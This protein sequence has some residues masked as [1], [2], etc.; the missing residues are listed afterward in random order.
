MDRILRE[1]LA[2][3]VRTLRAN[4]AMASRPHF[5]PVLPLILGGDDLFA[6]VPAP[7]AL[8]IAGQLCANFER[9]MTK[10]AGGLGN[11]ARWLK[12]GV[13]GSGACVTCAVFSLMTWR[14]NGASKGCGAVAGKGART[15]RIPMSWL[16]PPNPGPTSVCC[17]LPLTVS[18]R[19]ADGTASIPGPL[20]QRR[21]PSCSS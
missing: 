1:A 9:G 5:V 2:T 4:P 10:L 11:S 6:L 3:P 8:D 18:G 13:Q 7:W 17:R 20:W 12:Y 16:P 14:A 15:R 19:T 21:R